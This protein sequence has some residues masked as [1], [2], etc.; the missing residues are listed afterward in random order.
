M[1][2]AGDGG[3]MA[4]ATDP[5]FGQIFRQVIR[6]VVDD[7]EAIVNEVCASFQAHAEGQSEACVAD[8]QEAQGAGRR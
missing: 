8:R 7:R 3:T 1:T 5:V 4:H 6:Q 2:G